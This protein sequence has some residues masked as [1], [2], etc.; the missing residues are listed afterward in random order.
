[1]QKKFL[2]VAIALVS[3][4]ALGQLSMYGTLDVAMQQLDL[5]KRTDGTNVSALRLASGLLSTPRLGFKGEN[6]LGMYGLHAGFQLETGFVTTGGLLTEYRSNYDS[7]LNTMPT[8]TAGKPSQY[9]MMK[10][11]LFN[12]QARVYLA[13]TMGELSLGKQANPFSF[14][15]GEVDPAHGGTTTTSSTLFSAVPYTAFVDNSIAYHTPEYNGLAACVMVSM[16][17]PLFPMNATQDAYMHSDSGRLMSVSLEYS[18][19]P[20]YAGMAYTTENYGSVLDRSINSPGHNALYLAGVS[21]DFGVAKPYTSFFSG[22]S[23]SPILTPVA[24]AGGVIPVA[25]SSESLDRNVIVV[26]LGVS[27]PVGEFGYVLANFGS[28]TEQESTNVG[29]YLFGLGYAYSFNRSTTLYAA[30]SKLSNTNTNAADAVGMGLTLDGALPSSPA[31][32]QATSNPQSLEL[33]L[34]YRF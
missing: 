10:Q 7:T 30:Y 33:G 13:G 34:R 32:P 5:G 23:Y 17:E 24:G 8:M 9:V 15:A 2:A 31:L 14:V 16:N 18:A 20:L 3:V 19:G 11:S 12:R 6:A 29:A 4:P 22:K 28:L 21:Y 25:A 27:V 1:M 26:S